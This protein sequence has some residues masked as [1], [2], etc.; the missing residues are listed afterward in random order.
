MLFS[1]STS[2]EDVI[3]L[4]FLT[5]GISATMLSIMHWNAAGAELTAGGRWLY[6]LEKYPIECSPLVANL[7]DPERESANS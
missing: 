2:N 4:G 6:L 5:P 3:Q 7:D 1:G